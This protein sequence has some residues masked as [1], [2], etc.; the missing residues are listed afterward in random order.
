M[1]AYMDAV[2]AGCTGSQVDY[3][4]V[5]T[6]RPLDAVL[7]EFIFRRQSTLDGSSAKASS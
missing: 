2:Q 1:K 7:S 5:D 3:T 4:M 6:S